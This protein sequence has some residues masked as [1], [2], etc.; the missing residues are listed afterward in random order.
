MDTKYQ[1]LIFGLLIVLA[2]GLL[3]G[4]GQAVNCAILWACSVLFI[5]WTLRQNQDDRRRIRYAVFGLFLVMIA[6]LVWSLPADALS[7]TGN[8]SGE[9]ILW[10]IDGGTPPYRIWVNGAEYNEFGY[11]GNE[12]STP[13]LGAHAHYAGVQDAV[14]DSAVAVFNPVLVM[15]PAWVWALLVV[16]LAFCLLT[17]KV[18]IASYGA[19]ITG[20]FLMLMLAPYVSLAG[21]L[22]FAAVFF[23]IIGISLMFIF[24]G[25]D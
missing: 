5:A 11:M 14:N 21:Y 19:A 2:A 10:H 1:V 16:W 22:R 9:V 20:G 3:F 7:I 18:Y 13:V 17:T 23:F 6:A 4:I 8:Q 12:F 15:Y 25:E 24:K